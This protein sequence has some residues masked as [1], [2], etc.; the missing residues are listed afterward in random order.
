MRIYITYDKKYMP[1]STLPTTPIANAAP[2][3][4]LFAKAHGFRTGN[5]TTAPGEFWL[6]RGKT[7]RHFQNSDLDKFEFS[8]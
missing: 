4:R 8:Y 2:R 6:W 1:L 5:I 7:I 3:L